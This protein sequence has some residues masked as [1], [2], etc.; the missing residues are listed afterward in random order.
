MTYLYFF[1]EIS[2]ITSLH[3]IN[4]EQ[5]TRMKDDSW[6]PIRSTNYLRRVVGNW[7]QADEDRQWKAMMETYFKICDF[8]EMVKSAFFEIFQEVQVSSYT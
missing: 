7:V 4:M 2:Y 5:V 3:Y 1:V 6:T 8:T